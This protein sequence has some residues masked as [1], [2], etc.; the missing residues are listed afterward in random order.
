[1]TTQTI[2]DD[3]LGATV[4][5]ALE[6]KPEKPTKAEKRDVVQEA[7]QQ[8]VSSETRLEDLLDRVEDAKLVLVQK[9]TLEAKISQIGIP[10]ILS[11]TTEPLV[12][13][14]NISETADLELGRLYGNYM[15]W[16]AY[17]RSEISMR[18]VNILYA[19]TALNKTAKLLFKKWRAGASKSDAEQLVET[20]STILALQDLITEFAIEMQVF[21]SR[22]KP[23][24]EYAKA[25]SR[26]ISRRAPENNRLAGKYA[27]PE[28]EQSPNGSP[29]NS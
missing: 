26:E 20:D 8:D 16:I 6:K 24:Q 28:D 18:E 27:F 9:R 12:F 23:F 11:P 15:A 14:E 3:L 22:L 29:T 2:S 7:I 25:L 19:K 1:M 4:S 17:L 5:R 21:D 13:P 10:K